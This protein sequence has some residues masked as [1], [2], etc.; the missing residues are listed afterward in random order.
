M[1]PAPNGSRPEARADTRLGAPL[2]P[3]PG[4]QAKGRP[5]SAAT[6][7][8]GPGYLEVP[9][10]ATHENKRGRGFGRCVVEAIEDVAR[11]VGVPQL[12]LCS[13]VEEHVQS[14]WKHLGF[15]ETTDADLDR[16]DVQDPDLIHMQVRG[17]VGGPGARAGSGGWR[18]PGWS[19]T[20]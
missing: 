16:L 6:I 19:L 8:S 4:L 10:V 1:W 9:F 5:L 18:R 7:R 15:V 13:T 2:D 3:W 17:A 11:A 14:T 12:L 20:G